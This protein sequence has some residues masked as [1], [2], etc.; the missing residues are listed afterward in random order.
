M[1]TASTH[2]D[3]VVVVFTFEVGLS[4]NKHEEEEGQPAVVALV[5]TCRLLCGHLCFREAKS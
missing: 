2:C 3:A 1:N 4:S 5:K